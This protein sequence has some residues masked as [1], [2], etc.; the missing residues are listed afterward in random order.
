MCPKTGTYKYRLD[1]IFQA[2]IL[3]DLSGKTVTLS[4][5]YS[6]YKKKGKTYWAT[7]KFDVI[8]KGKRITWIY[9]EQRKNS[10]N[11]VALVRQP[12]IVVCCNDIVSIYVNIW[13]P[14]GLVDLDSVEW[15]P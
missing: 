2:E 7:Y 9:Q 8:K 4:Y 12:V 11:I 5:K 14:D 15:C 1:K 3:D 6:L 10:G 13:S